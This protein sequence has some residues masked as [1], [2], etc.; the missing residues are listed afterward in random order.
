MFQKWF[1]SKCTKRTKVLILS[2]ALSL[3]TLVCG[4]CV[5][6]AFFPSVLFAA[7][8]KS[9][10]QAKNLP[11]LLKAIEDHY[12][13]SNTLSADFSQKNTNT[14]LSQT[15]ESS[16]RIFIKLPSKI[17]WET[18]KPDSSLLVSDGSH[19]WFYTPPFMEGER[20]QVIQKDA[21]QVQSQL[22]NTLL[23]GHFSDAPVTIQTKNA[24]TFILTPKKGSAGTVKKA[25]L[26]VDA[27]KKQVRKITLDHEGGNRTE[28]EL[29]RLE[30]AQQMR[31]DFFEFKAPPNTDMIR[32]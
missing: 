17:R 32:E 10:Q 6:T 15:K 11:P 27:K 26:E 4:S 14:L 23:A 29:S 31:D 8:P 22:A 9:S 7:T 28:I 24:T 1:Q 2:W 3:G 13:E 16:G 20:G 21:G 25:T 5:A 19:Y 30:L 12:K 18:Q